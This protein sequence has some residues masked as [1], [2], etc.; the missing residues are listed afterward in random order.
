MEVDRLDPSMQCRTDFC[1]LLTYS[2]LLRGTWNAFDRR[3]S[4]YVQKN[5]VHNISLL[6]LRLTARYRSRPAFRLN[7]QRFPKQVADHANGPQRTR[8]WKQGLSLVAQYLQKSE[9]EP[10]GVLQEGTWRY[11]HSGDEV[12][13][14]PGCPTQPQSLPTCAGADHVARFHFGYR[15]A[16]LSFVACILQPEPATM[17]SCVVCRTHGRS[18]REGSRHI[19]ITNH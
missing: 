13:R 9:L 1:G 15:K 11:M 8:F 6:R 19:W 14:D 5:N 10:K 4:A 12:R 2:L 18:T 7:N 17:C 16:L 3:H